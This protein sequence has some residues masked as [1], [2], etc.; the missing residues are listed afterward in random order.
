[1]IYFNKYHSEVGI[2]PSIYAQSGLSNLF[3]DSVMNSPQFV[4]N[5]S[6][7]T[8]TISFYTSTSNMNL[9]VILPRNTWGRLSWVCQSSTS[10]TMYLTYKNTAGNIVQISQICSIFTGAPSVK[11]PA[12]VS[13]GFCSNLMLDDIRW[14]NTVRTAQQI[15]NTWNSVVPAN[16]LN[17]NYRFDEGFS[18]NLPPTKLYDS[19]FATDSTRALV[20]VPAIQFAPHMMQYSNSGV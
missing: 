1:M 4:F 5:D 17:S 10:G 12:V 16:L 19:C 14:W 3:I 11:P 18:G 7:S 13:V 6:V 15:A 9:N 20:V 2:Q 8:N